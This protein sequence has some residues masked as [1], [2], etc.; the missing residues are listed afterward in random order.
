MNFK[1]EI[2]FTKHFCKMVKARGA[3]WVAFVGNMRHKNGIPDRYIAH[4][5]F[6]GWI[7]FKYHNRLCTDLQRIFIRDMKAKHDVAMVCRLSK[8][9][10]VTF[11]DENAVQHHNFR[12]IELEYLPD[13]RSRGEYLLNQCVFAWGNMQKEKGMKTGK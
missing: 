6:R 3:E 9:G 7:E 5:I 12:V 1:G 8:I 2:E 11:E 10:R 4:S 13:D